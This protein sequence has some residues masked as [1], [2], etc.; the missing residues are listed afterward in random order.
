MEIYFQIIW[1]RITYIIITTVVAVIVVGII[2]LLTPDYYVSTTK[3]LIKPTIGGSSA[4]AA[5]QYSQQLAATFSEILQSYSVNLEAAD[6]LEV[7][8]LPEYSVGIIPDSEL[9]QIAVTAAD[10]AFAKETAETLAIILIERVT[11]RYGANLTNIET[12]LVDHVSELENEINDLIRE[13]AELMEEVPRDT[14]RVAEINRLITSREGTYNTMLRSLNETLISQSAQS[15]VLSVF[16]PA[17]IPEQPA[18][19]STALNIITGLVTGLIGGVSIAFLLEAYRPRLYSDT[20]VEDVMETQILDKIP[21]MSNDDENENDLLIIESFRK[22]RTTVEAMLAKQCDGN[23][24]AFLSYESDNSKTLVLRN[25]GISL[26][27][28]FKRVVLVDTDVYRSTLTREFNLTETV[29]ITNVLNKGTTLKDAIHS[30]SIDN[31]D[32]ISV[33]TQTKLSAE[34]YGSQSMTELVKELEQSYDYVLFDAAPI[35]VVSDAVV[36]A[37]HV[38]T[39][40]FVMRPDANK[41]DASQARKELHK[42]DANLLG[43]I[44]YGTMPDIAKNR[45]QKYIGS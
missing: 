36:V 2:S 39:S 20:Q 7:E 14:I 10:P 25:L 15:N 9:L 31:L 27:N 3:L 23:S 4:Y 11:V 17:S 45:T 44:L 8:E 34:F 18:G 30:S 13:R 29:G 5:S 40:I 43:V 33:G 38:C 28:N 26:A 22:L 32:V 16:E 21:A 1:K 41:A 6:R 12:T 35:V 24:V 37:Q 19:P 42:V